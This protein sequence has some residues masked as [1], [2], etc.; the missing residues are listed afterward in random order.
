MDLSAGNSGRNLR[1]ELAEIIRAD[2]IAPAAIARECRIETAKLVQWLK[3]GRLDA[4]Y[5]SRLAHFLD[6]R[7]TVLKLCKEIGNQLRGNAVANHLVKVKRLIAELKETDGRL[8]REELCD[9]V[10]M[11]LGDVEKIVGLMQ[12]EQTVRE[13]ISP[14]DRMVIVKSGKK[15]VG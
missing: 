11:R 2:A 4:D 10:L 3:G 15:A 5:A 1:E 13:S 14:G 12:H 7:I 8:S 9:Q 6:D